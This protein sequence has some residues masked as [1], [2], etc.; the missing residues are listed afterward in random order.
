MLRPYSYV[1]PLVYRLTN[2]AQ[3]PTQTLQNDHYNTVDFIDDYRLLS[4][5][6]SPC[7][8]LIDT[9]NVAG[10]TPVQT[11]FHLSPHFGDFGHPP[12]LL[13]RGAYKPSPAEYLAPFHQDPAQRIVAFTM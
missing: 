6:K 8:V 11:L 3:E 13:E 7:I 1:K 9:E 4:T 12:H 10:G 2:N 5:L